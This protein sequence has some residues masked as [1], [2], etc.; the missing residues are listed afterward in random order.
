MKKRYLNLWNRFINETA[1]FKTGIELDLDNPTTAKLSDVSMIPGADISII[2]EQYVVYS[3][4]S[5]TFTAR[6]AETLVAD[7]ERAGLFDYVFIPGMRNMEYLRKIKTAGI[8]WGT[9]WLN[10]E[11]EKN[12]AR[13][14]GANDLQMDPTSGKMYTRDAGL[15]KNMP[16]LMLWDFDNM[17]D[18]MI[19]RGNLVEVDASDSLIIIAKLKSSIAPLVVPN[20]KQA[21]EIMNL[22]PI[23]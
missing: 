22:E 1:L 7:I 2:G 3:W 14:L 12:V 4:L 10:L 21:K 19:S 8:S 18:V 11:F 6:Q 13:G 15:P 5:K 20:Y 23:P 16:N 17:S 9:V